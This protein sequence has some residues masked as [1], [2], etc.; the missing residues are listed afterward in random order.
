MNRKKVLAA[1]A[2]LVA[3]A[4]AV[5]FFW[6]S[7]FL[8]AASSVDALQARI[9]EYAPFSHLVFFLFQL[10][11]VIVAP[12][13]SNLVAATGGVLFGTWVSFP[14]TMAAVV[15]GSLT[16]FQVARTLGQKFV[17]RVVSAKVSEKYLDLIRSKT[18][19]FLTMAFLFPMFPDDL[20]CILAGLTEIPF[21]RFLVI[22]LLARPWGLLA[23]CALGGATLNLPPWAMVLTAAAG[24]VLFVLGLKYGDRAEE[25]LLGKL[26]QRK[27]SC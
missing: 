8:D 21:R 26:R 13:P 10:T 23:A 6:K 25:Y 5:F 2:A 22:V 18:D 16:T 27:K 7:G 20:I 9:A 24:A 19:I 12:I 15:L 3:V 1:A 4:G 11:A 14:I 17:S